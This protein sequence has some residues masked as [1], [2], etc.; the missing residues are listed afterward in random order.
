[1]NLKR[2]FA[3]IAMGVLSN[4]AQAQAT[5]RVHETFLGGEKFNGIIT[6]S[7]NF[8]SILSV[9]GT[10]DS[11]FGQQNVSGYS[12]GSLTIFTPSRRGM[13][14]T[15]PDGFPDGYILDFAWDYSSTPNLTLPVFITPGSDASNPFYSNSINGWNFATSS[16]ISAIP[17]PTEILMLSAGLLFLFGT[18][19]RRAKANTFTK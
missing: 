18:G 5:Y 3:V 17:E 2:I 19:K 7:N 16:Y 14:L 6:F 1:M 15:G 9:S 4:L 8:E 13:S 10:L 11:V 12:S